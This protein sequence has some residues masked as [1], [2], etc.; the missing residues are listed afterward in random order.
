RFYNDA[1]RDTRSLREQAPVRFLRL[2]GRAP[3]PG[4]VELVDAPPPQA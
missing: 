3:M 1:V 4:Y 2:A